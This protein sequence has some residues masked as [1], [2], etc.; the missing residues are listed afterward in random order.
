LFHWGGGNVRA[1]ADVI[2]LYH[3][4]F[5]LAMLASPLLLP[6]PAVLALCLFVAALNVWRRG[7]CPL[8]ELEYHLR[9]KATRRLIANRPR[10]RYAVGDVYLAGHSVVRVCANT[11][12]CR[13]VEDHIPSQS[14]MARLLAAIGIYLSEKQIRRLMVALLIL[15]PAL[16]Y[17]KKLFVGW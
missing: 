5:T 9:R 3:G 10:D 14:V 13:T 2:Y 6:W 12:A 7:K 1:L 8:T 4:T 16:A 11:P 17:G 15:L